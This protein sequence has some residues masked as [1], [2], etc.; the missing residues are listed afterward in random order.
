MA[1][2]EAPDL[3]GTEKWLLQYLLSRPAGWQVY[4][5]DLVNRVADSQARIRKAIGRLQQKGYLRITRIRDDIQQFMGACWEVRDRPNPAWIHR[6]SDSR[7]VGSQVVE[8]DTLHRSKVVRSNQSKN[9]N[10]GAAEFKWA[11]SGQDDRSHDPP[12][13]V[14]GRD[15]VFNARTAGEP[16]Q[17]TVPGAEYREAIDV[18]TP[19]SCLP[20][21]SEAPPKD[22]ADLVTH[23]VA[24]GVDPVQARKLARQFPRDRIEQQMEWMAHRRADN[25]GAYLAQAIRNNY[26][27][28]ARVKREADRQ[29]E[30]RKT[31]EA[32]ESFLSRVAGA[33]MG[34]SPSGQE[35]RVLSINDG[36]VMLQNDRGDTTGILREQ[37]TKWEWV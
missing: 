4:F 21:G 28:P 1:I 29:R 8:N 30:A 3:N 33:K 18:D 14:A 10:I 9:N 17:T 7:I 5:Q 35:W 31:S 11:G 32:V 2:I 24:L 16:M 15:F 23:L 34:I 13:D 19:D 6:V 20:P 36:G 25:P 37:S 27:P 22:S 12:G 26:P